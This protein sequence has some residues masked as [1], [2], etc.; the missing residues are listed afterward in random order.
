MN[1]VQTI[2]GYKIYVLESGR[3]TIETPSRIVSGDFPTFQD[4]KREVVRLL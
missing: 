1:L 3:F 2:R 4:A